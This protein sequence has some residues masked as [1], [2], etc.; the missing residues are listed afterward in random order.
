LKLRAP[1]PGA[2]SE[3]RCPAGVRVWGQDPK[4]R[5]YP[6]F[7]TVKTSTL[8][9]LFAAA[10]LALCALVVVSLA[11]GR[12]GKS[13]KH[14]AGPAFDGPVMPA[15]TRA[16]DFTLH[17]QYGRPIRMA[18]FRGE[19]VIVS[20]L[21]ADCTSSCPAQAQQIKGALDDLNQKIPVLAISVDPPN[22][23]PASI[24]HFNAEQGVTGR[25]RWAVGSRP[26][27]AKVWRAFGVTGQSNQAEHLS[28]IL[29]VDRRG[30]ERVGFPAQETT[31]ERLAHD[32]RILERS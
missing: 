23:T 22:D 16:P 9:A 30:Y 29:L 14:P 18:A 13:G 25:I 4:S 21:Y 6:A 7:V 3:Y 8:V 19:T 12:G 11:V 26:E 20:F 28:H 5:L 24:A 10:L 17:D 2:Q 15:G 32:L 27:L 1:A 31:P